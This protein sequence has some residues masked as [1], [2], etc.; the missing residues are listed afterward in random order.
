MNEQIFKKEE[1][2]DYKVGFIKF[3]KGSLTLSS[4]RLYFTPKKSK[5]KSFDIPL[6]NILSV[7]SQKARGNGIE[8]LDI[9]YSDGTQEKTAR[10]RHFSAVSGLGLGLYSRLTP[11]YFA[12]WEQMIN[13]A[14]F[15]KITN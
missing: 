11:L 8:F 13:D 14:R 3:A 5:E 12:S 4:E 1:K 7:N 6:K 2:L 10:V 15:G 9:I